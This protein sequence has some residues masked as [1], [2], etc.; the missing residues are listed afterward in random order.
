MAVRSL[1]RSLRLLL[2]PALL[3]MADLCLFV[4]QTAGAPSPPPSSLS[5]GLRRAALL[6]APL[7]LGG[8]SASLPAVAAKKASLQADQE[9]LLAGYKDLVYMMQN[10]NKVTRKCDKNQDKISQP[11]QTGFAG[12]DSCLAQPLQVR[13]YLGQTSIKANLFDTKQ[14]LVNFEL[15]GMVPSG[16]DDE[17]GDLVEDFER[18]KREADEWAYSSSWAEANPGGGRDRT[19]DYLL[20]S[21]NLAEKATK[22]LGRLVEMLG[23]SE[24]LYQ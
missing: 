10:F 22:T 5:S 9:K 13:K 15:A 21:K 19:E 3:R 16:R 18:Y 14:M 20:R 12:P 1:R 7:S 11:L 17:Y 23:I 2:L 4:P 8:S 24:N 6:L